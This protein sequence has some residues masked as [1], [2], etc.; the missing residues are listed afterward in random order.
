[1]VSQQIMLTVPQG[2]EGVPI[3]Y[4]IATDD[5]MTSLLIVCF[6]VTV[7]VLS[8]MGRSFAEQ[9]RQFFYKS[10]YDSVGGIMGSAELRCQWFLALEMCFMYAIIYFLYL[11]PHVSSTYLMGQNR[12]IGLLFGLV[13]AFFLA[14][15][16]LTSTVNW[17]FFDREQRRRFSSATLFLLAAE[18]LCILPIVYIQ[19]YFN[20]PFRY[21]VI[22]V[23][24]VLIIFRLLT[25]YKQQQ[26]FF[27]Q[28]GSFLGFIIYLCTLEITPFFILWGVLTIISGSLT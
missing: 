19:T 25:I 14:K 2:V 11:K 4:S 23:I 16:I 12:I 21:S 24:F 28:K 13:I 15:S 9:M 20:F 6:V 5:L 3:P 22:Y 7:I 26:I 18:G 27:A 8:A 1:M 17:V 10:K